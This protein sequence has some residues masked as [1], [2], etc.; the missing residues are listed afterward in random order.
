MHVPGLRTLGNKKKWRTTVSHP[1]LLRL[2]EQSTKHYACRGANRVE[3]LGTWNV[4]RNATCGALLTGP[5]RLRNATGQT[6]PSGGGTHSVTAGGHRVT[7][8]GH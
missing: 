6:V 8:S 4:L 5:K 1:P 2:H 3:A 7:A